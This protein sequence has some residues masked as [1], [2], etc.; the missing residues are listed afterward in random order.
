MR[1]TYGSRLEKIILPAAFLAAAAACLFLLMR[2]DLARLPHLGLPAYLGASGLV[3]AACQERV[4]SRWAFGNLLYRSLPVLL[5]SGGILLASSLPLEPDSTLTIPDWV[6]HA[7]EFAAL[8]FLMIRMLQPA[9]KE[10]KPAL[11]AAAFFLSFLFG[12]LDE[13][14]QGFVPGRDPSAADLASDAVGILL[15]LALYRILCFLDPKRI[16]PG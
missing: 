1:L 7:L 4:L 13:I 14:H 8:G 16:R 12:V 15:G 5:L 11:F 2:G 6:L 10:V 9:D 3:L